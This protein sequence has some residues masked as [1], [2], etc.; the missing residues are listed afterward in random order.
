MLR[1]L[2]PDTA[3]YT[4][5]SLLESESAQI[6]PVGYVR[7]RST[8]AIIDEVQY[9]PELFRAIKLVVDEA[10]FA[11]SR[12]TLFFVTGSQRLH[13]MRG[14]SESLAGRAYALELLGLSQ[15][16]M[17]R[18][19]FYEPF[20]PTVG[21]LKR[22]RNAGHVPGC[23]TLWQRI[24]RGD[25]PELAAVEHLDTQLFYESYLSTYIRR[26]VRDLS[27]VGDLTLFNRFITVAASMCGQQLNKAALSRDLGISQP[28]ITR[29]LT[30]LEASG[31]IFFLPPFYKNIRK[32]LVKT[33]KLYFTNTGL[34]CYLQG[35]HSAESLANSSASG[36]LFEN[37]VILEIIKSH[38]NA[39]GRYPEL[40]FYRDA[41]GKEID[42]LISTPAG[43]HPL[44]IKA[45]TAPRG[46][47][48]NRFV[49]VE[50]VLSEKRL[51]GALISRCDQ[52]LPAGD[53]NLMIPA[54]LI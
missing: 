51:E 32:R 40:Y 16:E 14:A 39:T 54:T 21:Y 50:D 23:D 11:G 30:I 35:I 17:E 7:T 25:M 15:R 26:D 24:L 12:Q 3:Y 9:V 45:T 31:I 20:A 44:E 53:N 8:P 10:K 19:D 52:V 27:Q 2:E 28:T 13:M 5:D 41:D 22:R 48:T 46:K 37:Y 34:V 18:V 42:L 4:F 33:P 49:M 47:D 1:M 38:L 6:D 29:W 43:I 36:H